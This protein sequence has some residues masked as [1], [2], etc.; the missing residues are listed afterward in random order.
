MKIPLVDLKIQYRNIKKQIDES[1][2]STIEESS[3]ILGEKV[4]NFEE[5]F[6]QY[7]AVKDVIGVG[8]GTDALLLSLLALGFKSGDEVITTSFSFYATVEPMCL[9]NIKPVFVDINEETYNIDVNKIRKV[10]TKKTKAI[11]PV[12]LYGQTCQMDKI[13]RLA[14]EYKLVIIEDACQAHGAKFNQQMVGSFGDLSCFSFFPGKNLGAYGDAG[15]VA[16]NNQRLSS[17]LRSLRNHGRKD[18][19]LHKKIGLNSRLDGIQAAILAVKLKFLDQWNKKRQEIAK[20]YF[21]ALKGVKGII[22]P[23]QSKDGKHVYHLF[24]IR[25][26]NRDKIFATLKEKGVEVGIHYPLPL[27]L[28]P[29]LKFLGYKKG[30]FPVSEKVSEEVLSLPIFPEITDEQVN[31]VISNLINAVK[32]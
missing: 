11:M 6:A 17:I 4:K 24:V 30:D 26:R 10:I 19:Y 2:F 20:K 32:Q 23:K 5:K 14:K 13:V 22:L 3:F 18:K 21:S 28:Q 25:V 27:H 8:N 15:A 1:I 9:L 16:T 12:H 29:A 7:L 31:Y